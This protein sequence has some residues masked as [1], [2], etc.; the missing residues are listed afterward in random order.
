MISEHN[1]LGWED[2]QIKVATI[3]LRILPI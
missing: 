1:L 2:D 3:L